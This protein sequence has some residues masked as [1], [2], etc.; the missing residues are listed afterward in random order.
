MSTITS[1]LQPGDQKIVGEALQ[2]ALVD[3]LDLSLLAKQAHW[4]V[5]GPNFRQIHLHLDEIVTFARTHADTVAERAVALGVTPDGRAST[6]A[7][8]SQVPQVEG[9]YLDAGKVVSAMTDILES[10]GRRMRERVEA[11]AEADPPTQDIL[12]AVTQDVEKH[13]WMMQAQR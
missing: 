6:V 5:I 11:T 1:P 4:N 3:L 7:G 13:H 9:G 12:I 10:I 8:S 2:G